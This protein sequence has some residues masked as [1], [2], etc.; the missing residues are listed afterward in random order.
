ML[1]KSGD[2]Y[3]YVPEKIQLTWANETVKDQLEQIWQHAQEIRQSYQ[4]TKVILPIKWKAIRATVT[5]DPNNFGKAYLVSEIV[6][7]P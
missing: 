1:Q 4:D 7:T 6:F 2:H 3:D 5:H